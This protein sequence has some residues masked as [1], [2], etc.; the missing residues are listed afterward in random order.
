MAED[1]DPFRL[2]RALPVSIELNPDIIIS[3][4][5]YF[6]TQ[7]SFIHWNTFSHE[8]H[9][10]SDTLKGIFA[11]T[12]DSVAEDLLGH[13]VPLRFTQFIFYPVEMEKNVIDFLREC[14]QFLLDLYDYAENN[15]YLQLA[16]IVAEM[17]GGITK[18]SYLQTHK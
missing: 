9:S 6:E 13:I 17:E 10:F 5:I 1:K 11:G 8:I 4:I 15:R 3:K 14:R 7:A 18:T 16:N 2:L 12:K